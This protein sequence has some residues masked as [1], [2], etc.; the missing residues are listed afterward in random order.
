MGVSSS[1]LLSSSS[2]SSD[3]I[4]STMERRGPGR[5]GGGERTQSGDPYD[6]NSEGNTTACLLHCFALRKGSFYEF[7]K[8][9]DSGD[10][11]GSGSTRF[12]IYFK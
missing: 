3:W 11:C 10:K 9:P 12:T 2:D 1:E 7:L 6:S 8:T 4:S 5:G